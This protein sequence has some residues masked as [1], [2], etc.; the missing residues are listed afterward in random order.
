M[1]KYKFEQGEIINA[2]C[3]EAMKNIADKSIDMILC[4]LPYQVTRA[5]WDIAI[6]FDR[7]WS[8]YERIIKDNGVIALFGCEPFSSKLRMSN[9]ELYRYDWYWEKDKGTNFG[10]SRKQPLKKIE[11]ISIFYKKQPYYDFKGKELEKPYR[12]TLPKH[13]SELYGTFRANG[14]DER[15]YVEYTHETK[16]N[17]IYFPR[18]NGGKGVHSCQKPIALLEHLIKTYTNEN[19]IILDNCAG[20]MS[21]VIASINT[22]RRCIAIEKD[23]K[24]YKIGVDRVM[25][26]VKCF[27][28]Q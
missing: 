26:A 19:Q 12:H 4:D 10:S 21:T 8:E 16:K 1:V 11:T 20:S 7:L 17:L 25:N 3:L 28:T 13:K 24:Y 22:N 9:E 27:N 15:E 2:D 5:N 23:E 6:P 14:K 18:D